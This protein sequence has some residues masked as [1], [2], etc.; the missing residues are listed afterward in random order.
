MGPEWVQA[1]AIVR[2]PAHTKGPTREDPSSLRPRFVVLLTVL[3]IAANSMATMVREVAMLF[4][5]RPV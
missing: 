4:F 1:V 3:V 2:L 5:A